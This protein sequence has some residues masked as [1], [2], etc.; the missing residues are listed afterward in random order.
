MA[1]EPYTGSVS[2]AVTKTDDYY[3]IELDDAGRVPCIGGP[4]EVA[5]AAELRLALWRGGWC[6]DP[7][8]GFPWTRFIGR[9]DVTTDLMAVWMRA[10]VMRDQ[11]IRAM[12][13][14]D[15]EFVALQR[16]YRVAFEAQIATGEALEREF[17]F[18]LD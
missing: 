17:S 10:V 12:G 7:D 3:D 11:R 4:A 6:V 14:C 1:R 15:V 2:F 5:Q 8:H 18:R 16:I 9:K 13:R